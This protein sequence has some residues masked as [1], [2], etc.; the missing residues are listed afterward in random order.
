M[1]VEVTESDKGVLSLFIGHKGDH[2]L[3][4]GS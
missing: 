2:T 4:Q 3:V 1:K